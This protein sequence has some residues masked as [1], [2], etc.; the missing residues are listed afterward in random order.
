M[1]GSSIGARVPGRR[2]SP[3]EELARELEA[4]AAGIFDG[5]LGESR[6]WLLACARGTRLETLAA[7]LVAAARMAREKDGE[8]MTVAGPSAQVAAWLKDAPARRNDE[9]RPDSRGAIEARI[10][11]EKN[12]A[13]GDDSR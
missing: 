9:L 1:T 3:L 5:T 2:E 8:S 10:A 11:R 4:D 13:T 6:L 7:A 12:A